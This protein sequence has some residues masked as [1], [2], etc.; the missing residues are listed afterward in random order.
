MPEITA[1]SLDL[2][3]TTSGNVLITET[4]GLDVLGLAIG[5][6]AATS[7][8][9]T[10]TSGSGTLDFKTGT[11]NVDNTG[12]FTA[13]GATVTISQNM[14]VDGDVSITA[15]AAF[16]IADTK[17]LTVAAGKDIVVQGTSAA[18]TGG[19]VATGAGDITVTAT[20]GDISLNDA[21]EVSAIVATGTI[22][23]TANSGTIIG[24][25]DTD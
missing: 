13:N 20:T 5:T 24:D 11:F 1:G 21:T 3:N 17:T 6:A 19:L 23:L 18:L 16:S 15:S 9:T 10:I 22:A 25:N 2:T 8:T 12:L 4:D 14:A 7:G